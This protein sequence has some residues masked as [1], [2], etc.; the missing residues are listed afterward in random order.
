MSR[1]RKNETDEQRA[2]S[3]RSSLFT[4]TN[5]QS[6]NYIQKISKDALIVV[7]VE[8]KYLILN[9]GVSQMTL[10][11]KRPTTTVTFAVRKR[12]VTSYPSNLPSIQ[13]LGT[14]EY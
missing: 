5:I 7:F 2:A 14:A 8:N 9:S 4:T 11:A 6:M 10:R 12:C 1:R 13:N 3:N